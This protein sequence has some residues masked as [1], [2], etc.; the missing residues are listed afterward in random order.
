VAPSRVGT[1]DTLV[2]LDTLDAQRRAVESSI[3]PDIWRP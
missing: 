2:K 3:K 1:N